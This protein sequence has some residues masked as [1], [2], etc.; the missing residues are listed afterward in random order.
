MKA[1]LTRLVFAAL[2]CG[3][4]GCAGGFAAARTGVS[5]SALVRTEYPRA[6]VSVNQPLTLQAHGRQWTAVPSDIFGADT[7]SVMDYAVYGEGDS[8]PITRHAHAFFVKPRNNRLWRFQPES[9]KAPGGLSIVE[10]DING[11]QWTAHIIRVDGER[12]WFSAMWRESGRQTPE[13]WIARRFSATPERS[14]RVVAEYRE[15]WPECLDPEAGDLMFVRESCLRGFLERAD[16]AFN[17]DLFGD[18][19]EGPPDA[20]SVLAKPPFGPDMRKLAGELIEDA[21]YRRRF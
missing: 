6:S 3:L 9:H 21:V 4:C 16:A 5:G 11:R 15:P 19:P 13:L 18:V 12:D 20:P 8:G 17:L 7:T 10:K 14:T 2:V 1:I